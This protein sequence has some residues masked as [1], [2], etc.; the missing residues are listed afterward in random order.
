MDYQIPDV[1]CEA[2]ANM[3]HRDETQALIGA[4]QPY[5]QGVVET[6]GP[7]ITRITTIEGKSG[8][9]ARSA[10]LRFRARRSTAHGN[11]GRHHWPHP[12]GTSRREPFSEK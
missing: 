7:L 11:S 10:P 4:I 2:A 5:K 9:A 6:N 1:V 12:R 3:P 8:N